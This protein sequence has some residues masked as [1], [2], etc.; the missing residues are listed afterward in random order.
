M[1]THPIFESDFDCLTEKMSDIESDVPLS[2]MELTA[3]ELEEAEASMAARQKSEKSTG[4]III[5]LDLEGE[6]TQKSKKYLDPTEF[7]IEMITGELGASYIDFERPKMN[8][9]LGLDKA[10]AKVDIGGDFLKQHT[11]KYAM[12]SHAKAKEAAAKKK[13]TAGKRWFDMGRVE[14][15]EQMKNDVKLL[16]YRQVWESST[17]AKKSDR[18]GAAPFFQVGTIMDSA[19]NFYSSRLTKKQRGATLVDQLMAD[20]D[21]RRTQRKKKAKMVA[22]AAENRGNPLKKRKK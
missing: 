2:D 18:R 13:E 12:S 5:D 10:M 22:A 11:L 17:K 21:F 4:D 15:D 7:G 20:V 16:K 9:Q 14:M 8:T 3:E 6:K 19:E 1:G